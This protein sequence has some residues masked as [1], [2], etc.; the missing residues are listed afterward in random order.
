MSNDLYVGRAVSSALGK[1]C[2]AGIGLALMFFA[3][4]LL[5]Y[6]LTGLLSLPH[7]IRLLI[8]TASGPVVGTLMITVLAWNLS[9]RSKPVPSPMTR[10]GPAT[11]DIP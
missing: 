3:I 9:Q 4:S 8:A 1:G 2:L 6:L 11:R 5:T 10:N 7:H